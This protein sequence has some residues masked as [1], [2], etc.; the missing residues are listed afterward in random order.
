MLKVRTFSD[1]VPLE[2]PS[3]CSFTNVASALNARVFFQYFEALRLLG[4]DVLSEE[5]KSSE[6]MDIQHKNTA[7][8]F[9]ISKLMNWA[10]YVCLK[11]ICPQTLI[12]RYMCLGNNQVSIWYRRVVPSTLCLV[13]PRK[14]VRYCDV[15]KY[16]I[17]KE[18]PD[19]RHPCDPSDADLI[20]NTNTGNVFFSPHGAMVQGNSPVW[21]QE[22][23]S[24]TP[25]SREGLRLRLPRSFQ[26]LEHLFKKKPGDLAALSAFLNLF[27]RMPETLPESWQ[28]IG[29]ALPYAMP[30]G[31]IANIP[32]VAHAY[33]APSKES[34]LGIVIQKEPNGHAVNPNGISIFAC[35]QGP[36][37]EDRCYKQALLF[38]VFVDEN[39]VIQGGMLPKDTEHFQAE[40]GALIEFYRPRRWGVRKQVLGFMSKSVETSEEGQRDFLSE[41][42]LCILDREDELPWVL[43]G[44]KLCSNCEMVPIGKLKRCGKCHTAYYCSTDCQKIHWHH[45]K[46][47]CKLQQ[48]TS[49][50]D[51]GMGQVL[52]KNQR[53]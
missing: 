8:N 34:F 39:G 49:V 44:K 43:P 11:N 28:R 5:D 3:N 7:S 19:V 24:T 50:H 27:S 14:A 30:D 21:I 1:R 41:Q 9:A 40:F 31:I 4:P 52:V 35:R 25:F 46:K 2:S 36:R 47:V 48:D 20:Q 42:T 15:C 37:L 12:V 18:C 38:A 16:A 51:F 45:H 33:K 13:H 6:F 29:C 17:C 23:F 26:V 22:K 10:A 32:L 53:V